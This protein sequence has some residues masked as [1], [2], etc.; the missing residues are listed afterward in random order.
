MKGEIIRKHT[1]RLK[2]IGHPKATDGQQGYTQPNKSCSPLQD[3]NYNL[4]SAF[5]MHLLSKANT[6]T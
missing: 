2:R 6:F 3:A 4:P 1:R 5:M